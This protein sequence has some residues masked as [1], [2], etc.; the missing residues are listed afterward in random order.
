MA[1]QRVIVGL[2]EAILVEHPDRSE[3]AGLGAAVALE[4]VGLG[5][6]GFVVS[7]VGQDPQ[8]EELQTLLSD[9][10]V[11]I[12]HVQTDPDLPT[13]RVIVRAI[14]DPVR[15]HLE[16][17]AAFDNL[18]ADFDLEDIAQQAD[19]VIYGL[20]TRRGGQ[21]RAEEDRFL[22]SCGAAL[23]LFDL[24]NRGDTLDRGHATTGLEH[25]DAVITDSAGAEAVLP[26]VRGADVADQA[27][28]L[29]REFSLMLVCTVEE[30]RDARRLHLLTA[31]ETHTVEM[32]SADAA[33][34]SMTVALMHALLRGRTPVQA[35]ELAG[36]VA[37]HRAEHPDEAVP[38]DWLA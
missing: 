17:R 20:L 25:A 36:R 11:E 7:R 2:G 35:A 4:A 26:G 22:P 28:R 21:T 10:G 5:E 23:K 9:A 16:A 15:R 27:A 13:G 38:T 33:R 24:T 19:A 18:Q 3:A 1:R 37:A 14:G 8:G 32:P 12:D 31:D 6:R 29:L 34:P 30:V